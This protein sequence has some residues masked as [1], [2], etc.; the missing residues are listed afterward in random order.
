MNTRTIPPINLQVGQRVLRN[1]GLSGQVVSTDGYFFEVLWDNDTRYHYR[2]NGHWCGSWGAAPGSLD[3]RSIRLD[4]VKTDKKTNTIDIISAVLFVLGFIL[5]SSLGIIY[6]A[7][8]I[9]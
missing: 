2:A 6:S 3:I 8:S 7:A 4:S 1:D 5:G 9:N